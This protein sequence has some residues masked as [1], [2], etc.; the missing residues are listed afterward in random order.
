M[1]SAEITV[2]SLNRQL[3]EVFEEESKIYPLQFSDKTG[4]QGLII[5][6]HHT[7]KDSIDSIKVLAGMQRASDVGV[8]G[9]SI[10]ESVLNMGLL[11]HLPAN[12]G[13]NRYRLYSSIESLKVYRHMAQIEKETA[14][15]IFTAENIRKWETDLKQYERDYGVVTSA[16]SGKTAVEICQILDG[17]YPPV[18]K[19]EHFYEFLYCQIY[20]YGSSAVHRSGQW[21]ARHVDIITA[22]ASR[23]GRVHTARSRE[24]GSVF[25]YFHSLIAFLS[26][27][28]MIGKAFNL[29]SLEDYFQKK[30]GFLIAGYPETGATNFNL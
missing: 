18:V 6:N 21:L 29:P 27:M 28:R 22:P 3:E 23:G 30:V 11:V 15:K 9:R 7:N 12:D 19:S 14:D 5:L 1:A 10:F 26:S 8:I 20:R 17:E 13:V 4:K 25:N 2:K 24:E 16:W